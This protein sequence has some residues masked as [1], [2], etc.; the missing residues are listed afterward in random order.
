MRVQRRLLAAIILLLLATA[1]L[2]A[3]QTEPSPPPA[4]TEPAAVEEQG[5]VVTAVEIRSEVELEEEQLEELERLITL[6]VGKP[7]TEEEIASTLRHVQATGIGSQAELYSQPD[8]TGQGVVAMLVLRPVVRVEEIRLEGELGLREG[9]LR[10]EIPQNVAEPLSEERVIQGVNS[11]QEHYNDRGYFHADVRVQVVTNPETRRATVVYRIQSGPQT[12]VESV[13]FDGPIAPFQPP[14]LIERLEVKPGDPF[15]RRAVREDADRLQTWLVRQGY[16]TARVDRPAEEIELQSGTV[17][18]TYPIE[19]GPKVTLLVIGAE[20]KQLRRRNLLPFLGDQG[21]DEALLLQAS[22]RIKDHY[23]REGHY[24]VEVDFD[25]QRTDDTLALTLRVQPGPEYTLREVEITGNEAFADDQLAELMSTAERSLLNLGSGKLVQSELEADLENIR[26]YYALQGYAQAEVGPPQV[27]E[28]GQDLSLEIPVEEGPRQQLVNLEFRGVESLDLDALQGGLPLQ[29]GGPFHPFLLDRTLG[30]IR[31]QYRDQGYAQA[32]VSARSD[33]NPDRTLVDVTVEVFE[34]EQTIL[35][36]VIVRGNRRTR[37]EVIQRTLGVDPGDPISETRRLEIERDLYR[38]GIF[39]SVQV[40]LSRGAPGSSESD[41]IV[42][43]E[44]GLPRRV[45]YSLGVEYSEDGDEEPWRPRGGF[46]FVHNNVAGRAFSLRT[47]LRASVNPSELQVSDRPLDLSFRVLFDQP[48]VGGYAIPLTYSV[49]YFDEKKD[50]WDVIR[51]GARI[52]AA[53]LFT[54]RRVSLAY[55]Y[56]FVDA[57]P[58]IGFPVDEDE[59]EDRDLWISSL[60]SSFLWD[61]RNDPVLATHGWSSF[62]QL[63]WAFPAL[64]A[65]GDFLKLFVQ[66]T[67]YLDPG[68]GVVAASLRAGAIEPFGDLSEESPELPDTDEFP[69]RNVFIDERFFAGGGTTHRAYDRDDLGIRG[70]T[71][72]ENPGRSGDFASVGGNGLLLFNLE[73]RFPIFTSFEGVVFYDAGN[74]WADWRDID[75]GGVKSGVGL[76]LRWLSPIGPIRGDIGWKLDR[77]GEEDSFKM[78]LTFGNPF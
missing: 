7:L 32:Q 28:T 51:Y 29:E 56:R 46:T 30:V 67:Q 4:E 40:E 38:L 42:R 47:D 77:E 64:G 5:P 16:R 50:D 69:N 58:D 18:L 36:R 8:E 14:A 6:E 70:Q 68:F 62:G 2:A 31:Q 59:R 60:L 20:E 78:H 44:E 53:K 10:R 41:L 27:E 65:Q 26:R 66:Q 73:Y 1:H 45:S 43:V 33:W 49:F 72:I 63:Q 61:R 35:D 17:R 12:R 55:D 76:G 24:K 74:I 21:Y 39:S 25:Q 19:V 34:G 15:A 13:T 75:P 3:A 71:L 37:G 52:E 11:L 23:Q 54:S 48:Y 57:D 22:Q 9:E